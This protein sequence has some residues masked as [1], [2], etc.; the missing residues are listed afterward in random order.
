MRS[1]LFFFI[2]VFFL[3]LG[4]SRNQEAASVDTNATLQEAPQR[5]ALISNINHL[6]VRD[7][8]GPDGEVIATLAEGD[9]LFDL[10]EISAFTTEVTLRG[11][12]FN[13]PWIKVQTRDTLV[14]WVYGGG[15]NFQLDDRVELT[16]RLM[17]MRLQTFF[18]EKLA[19]RIQDYRTAYHQAK[20]SAELATVYRTANQLRDTLVE[21]LEKRITFLQ[22]NPDQVPDI[23]WME[24]AL[25][26]MITQRVAEGTI[27]YLFM[28]YHQWLAKSRQTT[29]AEDNQFVEVCLT[30][31]ALDSIEYFA[32]DWVIQTSDVD[33]Y[34]EL[35]KGVHLKMFEKMNQ[36]LA[37]SDLFA[38]EYNSFKANLLDDI[39]GISGMSYWNDQKSILDELDAILAAGF[40][41]LTPV[42]KAAIQTRRQQF[43]QPDMNQ[44]HLNIRAGLE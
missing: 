24:A 32:P 23:S 35:G 39:E 7:T 1:I 13:E 15:V 4:C 44:I 20:T 6:R 33:F 14:G 2:P 41:M 26:G 12:R 25:P 22:Q 18:G 10:G 21:I 9:T 30:A 11:I 38:P 34:S 8:P 37:A 19:Q 5:I 29:G 40:G 43:E 17:Q 31:F 16:R 36:A 27:F 42:E 28:D 3:A